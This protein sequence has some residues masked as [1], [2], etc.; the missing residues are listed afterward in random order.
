[1]AKT[2][3]MFVEL[4]Q[5]RHP[6]PAQSMVD[7][8][9]EQPLADVQNVVAYLSG[10]H[11]LIEMMDI[12]NDVLDATREQIINGS[13]ILTDGEWLW[14]EDYAYYV[15]HHNVRV[16]DDLLTTIRHRNYIVPPVP[17]P[18]MVNLAPEAEEL[19]F[20]RTLPGPPAA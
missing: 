10:G 19:A 5:S 3:G 17:E 1:M 14:R 18:V 2:A 11:Y 20:G 6:E 4:A 15:E 16:P 7:H 9:S 13:S 12:Q 8:I